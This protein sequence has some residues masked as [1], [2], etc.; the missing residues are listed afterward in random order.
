M[1]LRSSRHLVFIALAFAATLAFSATQAVAQA[2]VPAN[3]KSVTPATFHRSPSTVFAGERVLWMGDSITQAGGYVTF[4]EYYL[5]RAFPQERFDIVAIGL[6]SETVSGLTESTHGSIRPCALDRLPRALEL[7][8]PTVVVAC[9]GMNDGIYHPPSAERQQAFAAGIRKLL[10]TCRAA[11]A[12]VILL[13]PPPFDRVPPGRHLQPKDAPVFGYGTPYE[14]YDDVLG[15]FAKWETTLPA[16]RAQVIDLHTGVN[17]YLAQRRQ[18]APTFTLAPDAVHPGDLGHLLMAQLVLRGLGFELPS[19]ADLDAELTRIQAD[20][21]YPLI[22]QQREAR[23]AGWRAAVGLPA[24]AANADVDC[25]KL[26][27]QID[28]LRRTT[29]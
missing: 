11:H 13:T 3:P 2:S 28:E 16:K 26:Q 19:A 15:A 10:A 23:S 1:L 6:N 18:T 17:A 5:A 4:V 7:V 24:A 12:R 20:P 22:K 9:Y 27:S 8:K 21:L 29:P 14:A 25:A